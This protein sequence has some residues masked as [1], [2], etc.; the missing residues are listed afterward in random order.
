M[1]F[2]KL[3]I[4]NTYASSTKPLRLTFLAIY[5]LFCLVL[6]SCT[7][8]VENPSKTEQKA[9]ESAENVININTASLEE[10]EK[11]PKIGKEIARRI[12]EYREKYGRFQRAE[13]LILVRGMSDKKVRGLQ[14]LIKVE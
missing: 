12:I 2:H 8:S 4:Y 10:L 13:H 1:H 7:N 5:C 6:V 3:F 9:K 11:L 14:N